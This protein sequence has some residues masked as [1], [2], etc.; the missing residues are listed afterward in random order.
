M[1][2]RGEEPTRRIEFQEWRDNSMGNNTLRFKF[3]F[4]GFR[5][6]EARLI[7]DRAL[8]LASELADEL[9]KNLKRI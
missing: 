8:K 5:F 9:E 7:S 1:T 3:V 6:V 2:E 4:M